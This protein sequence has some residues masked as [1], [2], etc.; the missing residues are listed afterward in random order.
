MQNAR[1]EFALQGTLRAG[2][3][4]TRVGYRT[5]RVSLRIHG[6]RELPTGPAA[7]GT[8]DLLLCFCC[9]FAGFLLLGVELGERL[10]GE[11]ASADVQLRILYESVDGHLLP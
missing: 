2:Q 5:L 8:C 6:R 4:L 7:R 3:V 10:K 9:F 1:A 11:V